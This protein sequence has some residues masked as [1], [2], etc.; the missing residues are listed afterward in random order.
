MFLCLFKQISISLSLPLCLLLP[1]HSTSSLAKVQSCEL[2]I[3]FDRVHLLVHVL[4]LHLHA[5]RLGQHLGVLQA[6]HLQHLRLPLDHHLVHARTHRYRFHAPFAV[7]HLQMG[8]RIERGLVIKYSM[9]RPQTRSGQW[10]GQ[11]PFVQYTYLEM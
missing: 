8:H 3:S 10:Q 5:H 4:S 9:G 1:L 7:L 2:R 6:Q 11:S